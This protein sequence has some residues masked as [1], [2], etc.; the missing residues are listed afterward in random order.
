MRRISGTGYRLGSEEGDDSEVV[1]YGDRID[2]SQ[3]EF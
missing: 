1:K 2:L 3:V